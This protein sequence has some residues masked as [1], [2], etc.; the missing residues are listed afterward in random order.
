MSKWLSRQGAVPAPWCGHLH[1]HAHNH[2]NRKDI[3]Q[4][5]TDVSALIGLT[6]VAKA[7]YLPIRVFSNLFTRQLPIANGVTVVGNWTAVNCDPWH[8]YWG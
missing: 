5:W 3:R 4:P 7:I 8:A 2:I 1:T 6:S